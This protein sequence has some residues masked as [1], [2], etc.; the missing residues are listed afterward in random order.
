MACGI[1]IPGPGIKLEPPALEARS[2]KILRMERPM[3]VIL[4]SESPS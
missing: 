2:H 1:L 4:F 3:D